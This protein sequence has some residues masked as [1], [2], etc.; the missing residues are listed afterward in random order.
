MRTIADEMRELGAVSKRDEDFAPE[1]LLEKIDFR[2]LRPKSRL[3]NIGRIFG[4][5]RHHR[6]F[7]ADA[8]FP[9]RI[10]FFGDTVDSIQ[11]DAETQLSTEPIKRISTAP[12]EFCGKRADL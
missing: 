2:R 7:I 3:K 9:V 6:R 1:L 4:A 11:F 8:D 10:E 12:R 5:R